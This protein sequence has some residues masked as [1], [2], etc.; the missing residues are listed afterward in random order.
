M[1]G[2]SSKPFSDELEAWL[3]GKKPKTLLSLDKVF[4]EKSFAVLFII[5]LAL[6]ALPAPTGGIS[7][8]FEAIAII[9]GFQVIIGRRSLWLP[10][11]WRRIGVGKTVQNKVMPTLVRL[12]RWFEKY[13]RPRLTRLMHSGLLMRF[14][15][16]VVIVFSAVAA[17]AIPFSGLD[18]LPAMGVVLMSLAVILEDFLLFIAGLIVGLAGV[19]LVFILGKAT[20]SL[21]FHFF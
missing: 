10:K 7:H 2:E 8:V 19:A 20:L 9:I 18:T 21:L 1:E 6:P 17:V 12:I 15:G 5:L 3:K 4:A 16:V 11:R 13:S 14:F